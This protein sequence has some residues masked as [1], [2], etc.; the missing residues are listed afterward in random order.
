[1]RAT[2]PG[3]FQALSLT[4]NAA[5]FFY[6]CGIR[7]TFQTPLNEVLVSISSLRGKIISPVCLHIV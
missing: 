3:I 6:I 2:G 4:K 5:F 7:R 1:M